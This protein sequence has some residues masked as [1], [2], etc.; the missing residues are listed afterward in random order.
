MQDRLA[1]AIADFQALP[2]WTRAVLAGVMCAAAMAIVAVISGPSTALLTLGVALV[3][4]WLFKPYYDAHPDAGPL[5]LLARLPDLRRPRLREMLLAVGGVG[6]II[7]VELVVGL[8]LAAL[9][10]ETGVSS[11]AATELPSSPP[12]WW[13]VAMLFAWVAGIGPVMEELVFRN[14]I[15]KLL[16]FRTGPT[17]AILAT[18]AGFAAL[19]VPSYGGLAAG[20]GLAVP[21]AAIFTG[22]AVFGVLY[23]RTGTVVVPMAAHVLYNGTVLTYSVLL[24]ALA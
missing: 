21:V 5:S 16:T 19:H 18:S 12:P 23:W 10:P 2:R 3:A 11:H 22:S 17:L 15:Q 20:M 13:A 1:D 24:P 8:T 6:A 4:P 14:G 9:A 7:S